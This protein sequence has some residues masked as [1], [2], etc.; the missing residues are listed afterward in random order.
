MIQVALEEPLIRTDKY[1][2]SPVGNLDLEF[3]KMI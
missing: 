1:I 3:K 2:K